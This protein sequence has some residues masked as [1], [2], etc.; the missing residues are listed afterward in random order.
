MKLLFSKAFSD[1]SKFSGNFSIFNSFLLSSVSKSTFLVVGWLGSILFFMPS[2]PA[3]SN[4]ALP[5]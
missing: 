5:K 4:I 3:A 1:S 2:R